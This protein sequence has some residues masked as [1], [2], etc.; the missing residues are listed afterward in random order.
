MADSMEEVRT[1]IEQY[2]AAWEK[3]LRETGDVSLNPV[4]R[5]SRDPLTAAPGQVGTFARPW[6]TASY[7]GGELLPSRLLIRLHGQRLVPRPLAHGCVVDSQV[8]V[9]KPMEYE[10]IQGGGNTPAAIQ[11]G[12]PSGI[13]ASKSKNRCRLLIGHE[14][15]R[16]CV[17]KRCGRDIHAA[18]DATQPPVTWVLAPVEVGLQGVYQAGVGLIH[19]FAHRLTVDE[20][21]G[22]QVRSESGRRE[23]GLY[24]RGGSSLAHPLLPAPIED[25]GGVKANSSQ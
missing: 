14:G 17:N 6:G 4:G 2:R 13:G 10:G 19:C 12:T 18:G 20:K 9:A 22:A 11:N 21:L 16:I 7:S 24:N 23:G 3:I 1:L 5:T 25:R 15:I 8:I